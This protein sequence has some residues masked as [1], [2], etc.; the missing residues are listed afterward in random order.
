MVRDEIVGSWNN[1][2]SSSDRYMP[3]METDLLQKLAQSVSR[4][5]TEL[6]SAI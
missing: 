1:G 3:Q 6:V 5:L 2:D 4:R